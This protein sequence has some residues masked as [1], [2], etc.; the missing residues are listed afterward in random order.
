M[1]DT[2]S[3]PHVQRLRPQQIREVANI[4]MGVK[5]VLAFWFGESHLTTPE[6]IRR[7]GADALMG[8]ETFYAPTL[9]V[10]QLRQDLATYLSR[11]H[12]PIS[13]DRIAVTSSGVSALM[14][15]LQAI[16]NPGD[17]VVVVTPVWPNL[18]EIPR[19]LSAEVTC[20]PLQFGP[21]GWT[22]DL[23]RL[24][25]AIRPGVAA[26]LINSPNNP[27]GWVLSRPE[28]E[29]ILRRC[30][31]VGTWLI[32][33]DVYQRLYFHGSCAPSF[34]DIADPLDRFISCNSFSKAWRMTGWRLGW[35][36]VP[37]ALLA[38]YGTLLEYNTSCAPTFVQ[39]A[40]R[41]ALKE[42]EPDIAELVGQI[43]ANQQRLYAHLASIERIELGA[44]ARGG[45]YAF[46]RVTGLRNS[47]AFCK[48]LVVE[49]R[50]G[51]AP[52]TAF[53]DEAPEFLRW[54][55]AVN[56]A[57]LDEAIDRLG[58]QLQKVDQ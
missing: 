37:E 50:L 57:K 44:P 56:G 17:K 30:R 28:Q 9:G 27:T 35:A 6:A 26:L 51:L 16:V 14:V 7:A 4:G 54:C 5:D 32:G 46:F 11:L 29:A 36:V 43:K 21:A 25:D 13:S 55:L 38:S 48:R 39:T 45:M 12:Q 22:L 8:G 10:P 40:A 2:S 18:C 41:T 34:L 1:H 53:G 15:A 52:G 33:D 42:C 20:V 24:I 3:R 23:Q 49:G 47:L 19:I 31:E 58:G